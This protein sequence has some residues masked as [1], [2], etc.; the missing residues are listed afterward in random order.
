MANPNVC[1][2]QVDNINK[3]GEGSG[4][5]RLGESTLHLQG[6]GATQLQPI[7]IAG[8]DTG[9]AL[10]YLIFFLGSKQFGLFM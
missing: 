5:Y 7:V 2:S 6:L 4:L 3:T 1:R 9:P 10:P 8:L